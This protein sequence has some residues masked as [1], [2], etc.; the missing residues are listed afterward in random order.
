[1]SIAFYDADAGAPVDRAATIVLFSQASRRSAR[2]ILPLNNRALDNKSSGPAFYCVHSTSGTVS[3]FLP[4][5]R[6]L[7]SEVRFFGVQA[8]PKKIQEPGFARSIPAVAQHY[9]EALVAFQPDGP[10]ALGGWSIGAVISLEM[11]RQLR[12]M[13][14]DVVLLVAIDGA[15]D[16]TDAGLSRW[17]PHYYY[18]LIC[19]LPNWM[20]YADRMKQSNL[21]YLIKRIGGNAVGIGKALM[22]RVRGDSVVHGHAVEG[23]IDTS[24]YS[25]AHVLF[26]KELYAA[27][28]RYVPEPYP[29]RAIV[30]AAI[31][32]PL[33]H[34]RQLGAIWTKLAERAEV[35][36][37]EGTHLSIV[38]P[39][40][41]VPLAKHLGARLTELMAEAPANEDPIPANEPGAPRAA[42]RS[43]P[44]R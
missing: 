35:V 4:M 13:G 36:Q 5:A 17:S 41:V 8:P 6:L 43:R 1:M 12:A 20:R 25:P 27:G 24:R 2:V 33:Y 10:I 14:R 42:K 21:Q 40:Y 32:E 28:S 7:D 19:N 3:D 15:P 26:M 9:V 22:A 29:G 31:V 37:V 11:A 34:L 23:F 38:D 18:K 16:N 30:Y 44:R 39:P